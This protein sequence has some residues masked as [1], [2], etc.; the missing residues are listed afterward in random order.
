MLGAIIGDIVGSPF[1]FDK[2]NK[3]KEFEL[4]SMKSNFTDD[5]VMT[6]AVGE[7]LLDAG[8]YA[9]SSVIG[10]LVIEKMQ[11]WGRKYP[12][13]GYGENFRLWLLSQKPKPYGSYGNGSA[14]RVSSVGWLYDTLERT[15][16]IARLTAMVSH[17]HLEGIKGAEAIASA[18][19]MARTGKNK[20]EIRDYMIKEFEYDMS[21][22]CDGI[23][24]NYYHVE[25]CQE[26]VPEAITAFLEGENFEDVI[27][28]AVSLGGDCD[29]LTAIAGSVAEAY[30]DIPETIIISAVKRLPKEFIVIL[31]K[32]EERKRKIE[33]KIK[34]D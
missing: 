10:Q 22:T 14:M 29:T 23:R 4:F 34:W 27:R 2:G 32:F 8:K 15:R 5:S 25:S 17:N 28:L 18:I 26:T 19:F 3:S 7:A 30:Y 20:K 6:I 24:P 1:E 12:Y 9:N 13:V 33:R 31:N 16:E 11:K 21:R